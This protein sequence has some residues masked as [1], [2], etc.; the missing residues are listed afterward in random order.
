MTNTEP[1]TEVPATK[2]IMSDSIYQKVKFLVVTFLPAFSTL[3][4]ALGTIWGLP[5]VEQVIGTIAAVTTFLGVL[6]GISTRAYANVPPSYDGVISVGTNPDTGV[7]TYSLELDSDP[8]QLDQKS[9][10]TFRIGSQ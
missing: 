7:K 4:F 1:T 10:V 9:S 2:F 8:E 5:A 3:Y 6:L